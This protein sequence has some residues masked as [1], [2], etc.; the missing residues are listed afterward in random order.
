MTYSNIPTYVGQPYPYDLSLPIPIIGW[1][2]PDEFG[3]SLPILPPATEEYKAK[4][5]RMQEASG[6]SAYSK[7]MDNWSADDFDLK[8]DEV[9]LTT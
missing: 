2:E 3:M 8:C 6:K 4:L 7:A 1:T 5:A 9:Q